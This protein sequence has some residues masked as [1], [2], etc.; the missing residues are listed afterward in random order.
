MLLE[1]MK[2]PKK[3]FSVLKK[4]FLSEGKFKQ[5]LKPLRSLLIQWKVY[6]SNEWQKTIYFNWRSA[7]GYF[8]KK[9]QA[10]QKWESF[11]REH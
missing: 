11:K 4:P 10:K 2:T 1:K 6:L 5:L 7:T 3:T 8:L 9:V